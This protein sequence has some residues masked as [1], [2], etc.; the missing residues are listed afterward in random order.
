MVCYQ[1]VCVY[2][3]FCISVTCRKQY[4]RYDYDNN[5][6]KSIIEYIGIQPDL[7]YKGYIELRSLGLPFTITVSVYHMHIRGAP[8]L[9]TKKSDSNLDLTSYN[10]TY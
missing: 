10:I 9:T 2:R 4:R 5:T 6:D 8:A 3:F 7:T 1:Y